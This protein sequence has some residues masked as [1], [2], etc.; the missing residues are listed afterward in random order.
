MSQVVKILLSIAGAAIA[1]VVLGE[2][3]VSEFFK[4]LLLGLGVVAAL[5][6]LYRVISGK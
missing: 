3:S 6:Y 1:W 4:A 2:G 5:A